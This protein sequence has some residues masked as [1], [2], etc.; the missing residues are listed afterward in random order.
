M[1]ND[2][3]WRVV[4]VKPQDNYMLNLTFVDGKQAL[5]DMKPYLNFGVFKTL[6]D[7]KMFYTVRVSASSITWKNDL[8]IAPELLY[9]NSVSIT[10]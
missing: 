3:Y 2:L 10:P 4:S 8:D 5:F 6:K 9:H 7:P 1:K